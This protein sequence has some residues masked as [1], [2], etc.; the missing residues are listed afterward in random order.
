MTKTTLAK[1]VVALVVGL[2]TAK[3][4]KEII[5]NNTDAKNVTDQAAIVIAGYVIGAIA[6]DATKEWTDAK[7]DRLIAWW[8]DN[9]AENIHQ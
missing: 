1:R 8:M 4:V 7:I 6:A 5:K 3:V 2:G 9:V